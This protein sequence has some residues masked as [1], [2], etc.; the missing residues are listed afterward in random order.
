[1]PQVEQFELVGL[2]RLIL[3]QLDID[4]ADPIALS[5]QTLYQMVPDKPARSCNQSACLGLHE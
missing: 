4:A 1:L 3:G 2:R 5:L